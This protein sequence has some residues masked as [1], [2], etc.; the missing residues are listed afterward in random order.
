MPMST[1]LHPFLWWVWATALAIST[2]KANSVVLALLTVTA[3]GFIVVLKATPAPWRGSF[4]WA[5]KFGA[6]VIIIRVIVGVL[7]GVPVPGRTLFVLPMIPL[8]SWMA[9]IRIGG[10]VTAE[11]LLATA[12]E[13]I[14]L[15]AIIAFLGAAASLTSP[16]RMLRLLPIM[17]Y[18]IGVVVVI[19]TSLFP[20]LITSI[21]R[22]RQAQRMRGQN[23]RGI[24]SWRKM[25]IPLLEESLA[26]SLELAA[27]MDSRGYGFSRKRSR[28]RPEKWHTGEYAITCICILS[29]ARPQY[30][31][32]LAAIGPLFS[33]PA[34]SVKTLRGAIG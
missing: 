18:E 6:W 26:R 31:L 7:I 5:L 32:V 9:G 14:I 15:A 1:P 25:L 33:A 34:R 21:A 16:H 29:V 3:T 10:A 22:I 27:A 23:N 12:H 28:Y 19:A 8:P 11:R 2:A 17:V 4:R 20:A 24:R 13:G 30:F